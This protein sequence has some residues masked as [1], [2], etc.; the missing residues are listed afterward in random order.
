MKSVKWVELGFNPLL[1][2]PYEKGL[3]DAP[4]L[5]GMYPLF[6]LFLFCF[7]LFFL[8]YIGFVSTVIT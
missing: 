8:L 4:G 1:W 7:V 6:R 2:C 5:M 3:C